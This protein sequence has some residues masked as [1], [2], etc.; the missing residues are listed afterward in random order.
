MPIINPDLTQVGPIEPGTYP[1]KIV[2]VDNQRSAKGNNMIVP[3]FEVSVRGS[4]RNRSAY[5]VYEGPGARG[6]QQLLRACGMAQLA[7]QYEDPNQPSPPFDTDQLLGAS[8]NVV[9]DEEMYEGEKRDRITS[10]LKA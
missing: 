10:Y 6:F 8:L 2:K 9:V 5:L 7:A 1:A 4:S 3:T